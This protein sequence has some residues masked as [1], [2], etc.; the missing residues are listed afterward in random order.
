MNAEQRRQLDEVEDIL[1]SGDVGITGGDVGAV[2]S[3]A[4]ELDEELA[5]RDLYMS[6]RV[7]EGRTV[8]DD[9]ESNREALERTLRERNHP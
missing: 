6:Q 9:F 7:I 5:L 3:L 4:Y 1:A 2:I 8:R